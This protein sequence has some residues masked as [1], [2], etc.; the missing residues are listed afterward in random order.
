MNR[1]TGECHG[2]QGRRVGLAMAAMVLAVFLTGFSLNP[3]HRDPPALLYL[4]H[5]EAGKLIETRIEITS[6]Q[7]ISP[8][9][10]KPQEMWLIRS[11][12]TIVSTTPPANRAV[13]FY[14]SANGGVMLIFIVKVRYFPDEKGGWVPKFQL[15][16]E[17]LVTRING[18]WQPLTT[19]QGM[20]GLVVQTGSILPNAE[21]YF[22]SLEFSFSTGPSSIDAWLVQ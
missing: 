6:G 22:T 9:K 12:D 20:P 15:N 3:F 10:S 18:R 8:D 4:A 21:G 13:S 19:G 7:N 1:N 11:G 16:E 14:K 17:P 5:T 2:A